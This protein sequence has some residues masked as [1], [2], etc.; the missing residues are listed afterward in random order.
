MKAA[1]LKEEAQANLALKSAT[2]E[3]PLDPLIKGFIDFVEP[4]DLMI[5]VRKVFERMDVDESGGISLKELNEGLRRLFHASADSCQLTPEDF[6]LVTEHG[7]FV[8][9]N[10]EMDIDN[11]EEMVM[12]Q[13]RKFCLRKV[14]GAIARAED[15]QN[16]DHFFALKMLLNYTQVRA[17]LFL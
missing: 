8:D 2:Q 14:C 17:S 15:D 12:S 9:E 16:Q 1:K 10:G 5:R 6:E 3:G 11:F 4:G 7:A 13:L